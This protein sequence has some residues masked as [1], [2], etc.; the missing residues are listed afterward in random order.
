MINLRAVRNE[1]GGVTID[2]DMQGTADALID[3]L[4]AGAA[5]AVVSIADALGTQ[6]QLHETL[7]REVMA[8][9]AR[10]TAMELASRDGQAGENAEDA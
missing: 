1:T 6:D 9:M 8:A 4:A 7:G 5:H 10:Y 3:E 2:F